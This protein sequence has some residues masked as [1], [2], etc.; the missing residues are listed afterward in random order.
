MTELYKRS[1]GSL[2]EKKQTFQWTF[3]F[4]FMWL[5][6]QYW[7]R[8][9]TWCS[10][11]GSLVHLH[12][13]LSQSYVQLHDWTSYQIVV[14]LM[15]PDKKLSLTIQS[16]IKCQNLTNKWNWKYREFTSYCSVLWATRNLAETGMGVTSRPYRTRLIKFS[17][18]S[19]MWTRDRDPRYPKGVPWDQFFFQKFY[20]AKWMRSM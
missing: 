16:V 18:N 20:H 3:M 2:T 4:I 11:R 9:L 6:V 7:G 8:T 12:R 10:R 5:Q 15:K 1:L 17:K 19:M 14:N 13:G